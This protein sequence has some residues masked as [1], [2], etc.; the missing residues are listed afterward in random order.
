MNEV[1]A[2][3]KRLNAETAAW[4]AEDPEHR[5]A[6]ILTEDPEHWAEYGINTVEDLHNYFD[7]CAER[8]AQ[9]AA[10]DWEPDLD[11]LAAEEARLAE[12][13]IARGEVD[14]TV[15][16]T[17]PYSEYDYLTDSINW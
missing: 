1:I 16:A 6:G 9:K 17:E 10:Y 2:E 11:W 3:I 4:L 7:A 15:E 8:E 5:A 13:L 14:L 12:E